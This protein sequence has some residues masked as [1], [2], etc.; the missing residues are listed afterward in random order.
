MTDSVIITD[1]K[2]NDKKSVKNR[3][4]NGKI[5]EN[6][7]DIENKLYE[8]DYQ[9]EN[10]NKKNKYGYY[11]YKSIDNNNKIIYLSQNGFKLYIKKIFNIEVFRCPD[12]AY[13]IKNDK[14]YIIKILEKKEQ[15]VEGSVETKLW[16]SPSLKR[17]Y[18]IIIGEKF[19]I[20]Y[21][22]CLNKYLEKKINSDNKKYKI[23]KQILGESNINIFYGEN[24]DYFD[25]IY[26]WINNY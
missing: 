10:L 24:N 3:A 20:E 1:K 21:A 22:L 12:E 9:K 5:F 13:I 18:E 16:A 19:V 14:N 6:I 8:N 17:E 4:I 2:K 26:N 15:G 23:L 25:K 7:T 11:L